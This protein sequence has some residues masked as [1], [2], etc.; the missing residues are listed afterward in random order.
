MTSRTAERIRTAVAA[1]AYWETEQLLVVY[2]REVEEHWRAASAEE[3]AI[4]ATEVIDLRR[5]ARHSI[6]AARSHTRSKLVR[7]TGRR[8]YAANSARAADRL[9]LEA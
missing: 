6:M 4:I 2:R 7:L 3:Q 1:G 8:A 5:W 9:E